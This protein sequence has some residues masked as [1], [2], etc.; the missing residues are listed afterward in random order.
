MRLIDRDTAYLIKKIVMQSNI[1]KSIELR[2]DSLD[3]KVI[4]NSISNIVNSQRFQDMDERFLINKNKSSL[5]IKKKEYDLFLNIGDW[6]YEYRI[7]DVHLCLGSSYRKLGEFFAQLELSQALEDDEYI[8]IIKNISK[9]AGEGAISRINNG[10][11]SNKERKHIRR[12]ILVQ[13][14]DSEVIEFDNHE[15]MVICRIPKQ[16]L[17]KENYSEI[18]YNFIKSFVNYAFTIEEIVA[19]DTIK[20]PKC[21][22]NDIIPIIYGFPT[23]ELLEEQK[24]GTCKIGGCIINDEKH[25]YCKYCNSE[26]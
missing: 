25:Y 13:A 14:L 16:N 26:F 22:G 9:L 18:A 20:C 7:P 12:S 3:I 11:K 10:L 19:N 17:K 5:K 21:S 2:Y 4:I 6:G 15:W 1:D 23:P 24:L 8:Y